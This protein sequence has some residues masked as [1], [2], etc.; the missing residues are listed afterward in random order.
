M[1]IKK[2]IAQ[3]TDKKEFKN[4]CEKQIQPQELSKNGA[5]IKHTIGNHDLQ[6]DTL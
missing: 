4:L 3:R 5:S 6:L 1:A 2:G